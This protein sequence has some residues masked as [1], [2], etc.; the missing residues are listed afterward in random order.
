MAFELS[1]YAKKVPAKVASRLES[2]RKEIGYD[3]KN[4]PKAINDEVVKYYYD[5]VGWIDNL[6]Y[7]P[8]VWQQIKK[9]NFGSVTKFDCMLLSV[10]WYSNAVAKKPNAKSLYFSLNNLIIAKMIYKI[11]RYVG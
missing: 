5:Y 10:I 1:E 8:E 3:T 11:Y 4:V 6:D 7:D 9:S 2:I